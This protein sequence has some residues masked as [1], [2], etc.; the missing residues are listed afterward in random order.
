MQ[1]ALGTSAPQDAVIQGGDTR[2]VI[3]PVFEAL[4][5]FD[6][7]ASDWLASDDSDDPAH[8]F[9]WPLCYSVALTGGGKRREI[10][11]HFAM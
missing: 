2:R 1:L 7:M 9:G 8:P 3:A 5:R 11:T 6:Q 4:E 10:K